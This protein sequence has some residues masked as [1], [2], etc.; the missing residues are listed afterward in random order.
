MENAFW[1]EKLL[2][3]TDIAKN[4]QLEKKV[5]I[6]SGDKELRC[7][8]VEC[9]YPILRYCHGEKK[10]AFF[11]HLNNSCCDYAEFDRTDKQVIKNIRKAIYE[12]FKAIDYQVQLEVKVLEH[13]YTHLLFTMADGSIVAVEIGTQQISAKYMD[14]LTDEYRKKGIAVKWIVIANAETR[15]NEEH[16]YFLKRY[17][18]NESIN[19]DLIVISW[20][21]SKVSQHKVDTSRYE[22]HGQAMEYSKYPKTYTEVALLNELVFEKNELTLTGFTA[23]YENWI[24]KKQEYLKKRMIQFD[25]KNLLYHKPHEILEKVVQPI[26]SAIVSVTPT[27]D[28]PSRKPSWEN[29]NN[30][31]FREKILYLIEKQDEQ[32]RDSSGVRWIKCEKC[33]IIDTEANFVTY[34][35]I[36][37]LNLGICNNCIRSKRQLD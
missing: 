3:A 34:G 9:Q 35:G 20:D 17:L 10:G 18:L 28:I 30:E 13:H 29:L 31:Q 19:K 8:D 2:M 5:R 12:H 23:R 15:V 14:I 7:P 33:G 22:Y 25:E 11:A 4:Y 32:A 36:G 26:S 1:G 6:A 16:T 27:V 21:A 24:N 37:R